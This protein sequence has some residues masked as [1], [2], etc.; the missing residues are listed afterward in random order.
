MYR[1]GDEMEVYDMADAE[2]TG[3]ANIDEIV[4]SNMRRALKNT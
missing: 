3:P 4:S 2:E 1:H